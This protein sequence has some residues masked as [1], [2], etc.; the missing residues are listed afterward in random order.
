MHDA[1]T[2]LRLDL[3]HRVKHAGIVHPVG[4]RLDEY[5]PLDA[6]A[7][8]GLEI[9]IERRKRRLVAQVRRLVGILLGWAEYVEMRVA[10]TGRRAKGQLDAGIRIVP[11][12][13]HESGAAMEKL[14]GQAREIIT[15]THATVASCSTPSS[16]GLEAPAKAAAVEQQRA[17]TAS[18]HEANGESWIGTKKRAHWSN[19]K[20]ASSSRFFVRPV[21]RFFV[22][23]CRCHDAAR[24]GRQ[25]WP[26]RR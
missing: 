10:R 6:N 17:L 26:S 2:Q 12:V 15:P 3:V 4:A 20:Q 13:V 24:S 11:L 8:R 9:G 5:E 18:R 25:G 19:K 23:T 14:R 22:P 16:R 21:G 7:P 1:A